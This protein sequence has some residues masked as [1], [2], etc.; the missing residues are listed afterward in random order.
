M[1]IFRGKITPYLYILPAMIVVFSLT[2]YP[3]IYS[4]KLSLSRMVM[5]TGEFVFTGFDNFAE[6]F[7]NPD[8]WESLK[9]SFIFVGSYVIVTVTL[10][11]I[12]ALLFNQRTRF[13]VVY[14]TLIFIPWVI[15]NVVAGITWR[16][17][18]NE[19]AGI[20]EG[21][22]KSLGISKIGMLAD[23]R[24]AMAVLVMTSVWRALAF[25]MLLLLAGL[26][27]ISSEI[28]ECA[29][30][31]G[32]TKWKR[33]TAI[34]FPLLKPTLLVVILL[35]TIGGMSSVDIFLTITGGGPLRSTEVLSLYMY[36][37][38]FQFFHLEFGA[39]ISV[40][41]FFVN[42]TLALAYIRILRS[43]VVY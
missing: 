29:L 14:M 26:Q 13:S 24:G 43:K 21:I 42:M 25:T 8:F 1:K 22:A 9:T 7:T 31:D 19:Q 40:L 33:F 5:G 20:L 16:W 2:V 11:L 27:G 34:I 35:L 18:F 6:L 37:E 23:P 28:L 12:L 36:R 39:A 38:G 17:L 4:F 41:L 10:G 3:T 32:C 30:I 15:S